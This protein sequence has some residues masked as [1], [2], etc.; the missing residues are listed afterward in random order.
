M[1][2]KYAKLSWHTLVEPSIRI[3]REG[4]PVSQDLVNIFQGLD[5]GS[6]LVDDPAWA[7]DFAPNG[8][9]LGVG[10]ILT[11]KRYANLLEHVSK[12]GI[13]A[14]YSGHIAE[15]T[16]AALRTANGI[17]T[18]D[19]LRSYAITMR[20]PLTINY[21]GYR[22]TS[23]GAP[24][25]GPVILSVLKTIEGYPHMGQPESRNISTH[26]LDEATRFGF[27]AVSVSLTTSASVPR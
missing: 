13:D 24:S 1:H 17:M 9:L 8:T 6:F 20:T 14:F 23:C 22:V 12:H 19:D 5:N 16:I 2:K 25:S 26:R 18:M 21:K 27:G 3:A 7:L 4:F 15:T 10:D 11:R